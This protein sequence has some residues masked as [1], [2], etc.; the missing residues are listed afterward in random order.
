MKETPRYKIYYSVLSFVFCCLFANSISAQVQVIKDYDKPRDLKVLR[1]YT[2]PQGNTVREIQYAH[3][4]MRVTETIVIPR[5]SFTGIGVKANINPDTVIKDSVWVL[6]FKSRYSLQVY[7]KKRLIRG[8]KAVFGPQPQMN[9]QMEGDRNTPEGW[10]KIADKRPSNKYN[11]FLLLNYPNEK[12]KESFDKLKAEGKIPKNAR[13]GGDVGIHGI[14]PRGDDMIEMG[15]G[16]T[17]GCI[18]L[19]NADMDDLYQWVRVG[20]K[21]Y[22]KK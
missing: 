22:I 20:T 6:I 9:K 19:K 8:Y 5:A 1:E 4:A 21:V 11:K 14:W 15:V 13:I 10:Y 2:D 12:N 7:Y 18:A 16:W 17:D 3:R